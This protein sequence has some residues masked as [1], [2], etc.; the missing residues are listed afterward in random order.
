MGAPKRRKRGIYTV[1]GH[2][3]DAH[4]LAEIAGCGINTMW[5]RLRK[6]RAGEMSE[7]EVMGKTTKSTQSS[8]ASTQSTKLYDHV[9]SMARDYSAYDADQ[10]TGFFCRNQDG[11]TIPLEQAGREILAEMGWQPDAADYTYMTPILPAAQ[12][13]LAR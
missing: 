4:T 13:R 8:T 6:Y 12:R 5:S 9:E 11:S 2:T 7:E 10:T 3:G 1:G